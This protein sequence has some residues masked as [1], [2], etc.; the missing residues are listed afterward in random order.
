[1]AASADP[2][3]NASITIAALMVSQSDG[4]AI[5]TAVLTR[6]RRTVVTASMS[7]TLTGG[8]Y[9]GTDGQNRP[10]LYTP[11]PRVAGSSVSHWDTSATPNLLMEPAI[12][13]DLT[14]VLVP[15]KDLT[16][17]LLKDLGW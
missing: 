17:P 13:A 8:Q 3:L 12:S 1:M 2:V 9:I 5:K 11:N 16:V 6:S 14:I 10:L 4:L 15:P 7:A